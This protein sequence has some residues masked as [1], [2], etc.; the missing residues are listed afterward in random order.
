MPLLGGVA[1]REVVP[2]LAGAGANADPAHSLLMHFLEQHS[3]PFLH[4]FPADL[5]SVEQATAM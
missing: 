5:H 1:G 3:C 4:A 2:V